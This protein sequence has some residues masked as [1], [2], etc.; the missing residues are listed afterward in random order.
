MIPDTSAVVHQYRYLLTYRKCEEY[1]CRFINV[2]GIF[3]I[4]IPF[5]NPAVFLLP[6]LSG[7]T[8]S[9]V[10]NILNDIT[11]V[12]LIFILL[13]VTQLVWLCTCYNTKIHQLIIVIIAIFQIKTV[14]VS[15]FHG[16]LKVVHILC[17]CITFFHPCSSF[18]R[19]PSSLL[20]VSSPA[21]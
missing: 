3:R 6:T 5:L 15:T 17:H 16:I 7:F 21:L 13:N 2:N 18:I 4:P 11:R 14:I 12:I 8:S 19:L 20:V 1:N 9:A 10:T